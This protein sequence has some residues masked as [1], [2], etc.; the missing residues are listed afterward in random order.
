MNL[1]APP[2]APLILH[3]G[4][5]ALLFAHIAGGAV[6]LGAGFVTLFARRGGRLHRRAGA[7]FFAGMVAMAGVG[8]GVAPFL[9]EAQWV[10]TMAGAVTL[11]LVVTGWTAARN[12]GAPG[13]IEAAGAVAAT[14]MA[15]AGLGLL[16]AK[17]GSGRLEAYAPAFVFAAIAGLAAAADWRAIGRG[18]LE[19]RE[20]IARHLWRMCAAL[21]I[22]SGAFFLGQPDFVPRPIRGTALAAAPMLTAL[23][24]MVYEWVRTKRGAGRPRRAAAGVA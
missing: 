9:P 20:R 12:R 22:A 8:A 15:L 19:R 24:L 13:R 18:G 17:A 2:G 7:L 14:G 4:A 16:A 10:N 21:A 23:A 3:L 6:G 11:Y 5:G 1:E